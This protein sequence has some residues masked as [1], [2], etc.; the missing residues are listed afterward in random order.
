MVGVW[1]EYCKVFSPCSLAEL[2]GNHLEGM[3]QS[4]KH[5]IAVHSHS[6]G[7]TS[8][9]NVV[10]PAEQ[11]RTV[12]KIETPPLVIGS[13][14]SEELEKKKKLK[15]ERCFMQAIRSF[16]K[17]RFGRE[18]V[19]PAY[20]YIVPLC[21]L[22]KAVQQR[23]GFEAVC[24]RSLWKD[25]ALQMDSGSSTR[26]LSHVARTTYKESLLQLEQVGGFE[27]LRKYSRFSKDDG[28]CAKSSRKRNLDMVWESNKPI[29][30]RKTLPQIGEVIVPLKLGIKPPFVDLSSAIVPSGMQIREVDEPMRA[31]KS[32]PIPSAN[33]EEGKSSGSKPSGPFVVT[34][35]VKKLNVGDMVEARTLHNNNLSPWYSGSVLAVAPGSKFEGGRRFKV[36]WFPC[37]PSHEPLQWIPLLSFPFNPEAQDGKDSACKPIV[38]V[39]VPNAPSN[40]TGGIVQPQV[41]DVIEANSCGGWTNAEVVEVDEGHKS[42]SLRNC[43]SD[44]C[45]ETSIWSCPIKQLRPVHNKTE[46]NYGMITMVE[47]ANSWSNQTLA[48]QQKAVHLHGRTTSFWSYSSVELMQKADLI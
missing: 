30:N 10:K 25:V 35:A 22:W 2:A 45:S 11:W 44:S 42:V 29:K 12:G 39:R 27:A 33:D 20:G 23:D 43:D 21:E 16:W 13:I 34:S 6:H 26:Q 8:R 19:F 46:E 48:P 7:M 18:D 4:N 3:P 17:E 9:G 28:K 37:P 31:W 15:H 41:G 32:R 40:I 14:I 36:R 38:L 24:Q 1:P 5:G 47:N